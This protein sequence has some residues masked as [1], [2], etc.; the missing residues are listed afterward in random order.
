MGASIASKVNQFEL[1]PGM[2]HRRFVRMAAHAVDILNNPEIESELFQWTVQWAS[3]QVIEQGQDACDEHFSC[4]KTFDMKWV[5]RTY[6]EML[7]K[8]Q[9]LHTVLPMCRL[10]NDARNIRLNGQAPV[11]LWTVALHALDWFDQME[12]ML[13]RHVRSTTLWFM[14]RTRKT[15]MHDMCALMDAPLWTTRTSKKEHERVW[16]Y[17]P[18][19]NPMIELAIQ[20]LE[21]RE[22]VQALMEALEVI[23][24]GFS[25]RYRFESTCKKEL[26][27]V[28]GFMA[29]VI[30]WIYS[31]GEA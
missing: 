26:A 3:R 15:L 31:G 1:F 13:S 28:H 9:T 22:Q 19:L 6:L 2:T 12:S 21:F 10:Y 30:D 24:L 5:P 27:S 4:N 25:L 7:D 18:L 8:E 14:K 11:I 16:I 29:Q 23:T 20:C 17:E